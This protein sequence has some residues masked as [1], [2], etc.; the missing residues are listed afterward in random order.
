MRLNVCA[1]LRPL[2]GSRQRPRA[3]CRVP[4]GEAAAEIPGVEPT[5]AECRCDAAAH[6]EA[7][8]AI[9]E[10]WL[11]RGELLGPLIDAR[12]IPPDRAFHHV[13][14]ARVVMRGTGI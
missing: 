6:V 10:D 5:L 4:G 12:G 3:A 11:V 1:G 8:G 7:I 2:L 14:V 13:V 9:N